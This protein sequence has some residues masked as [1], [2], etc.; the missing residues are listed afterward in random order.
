MKPV[1]VMVTLVPPA[2]GPE[3]GLTFEIAGAATKVNSSLALTGLV[4]FGVVTVT[5]TSPGACA[6]A[7]AVIWV[8]VSTVKLAAGV[9]PKFT[10][11][12]P[13]RSAPVMV[14]LVP[15]IAGPEPGLTLETVG[16]AT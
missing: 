5:S 12:A 10:S 3:L 11:V 2:A 7:V 13:V 8:G 15:P 14:T 9:T 16:V 1:P 4:P 6:G